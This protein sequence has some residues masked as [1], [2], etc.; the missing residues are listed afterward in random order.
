MYCPLVGLQHRIGFLSFAQIF[1]DFCGI[2]SVQKV[3]IKFLYIFG[4]LIVND[5]LTIPI[6]L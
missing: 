5:G 6:F 1:C 2:L 4:P 3:G